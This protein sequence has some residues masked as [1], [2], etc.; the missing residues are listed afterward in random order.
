MTYRIIGADQKEYGPAEAELVNDWI[1]Q[2]RMDGATLAIAEGAPAWKPLSAYPEFAAALAQVAPAPS[3]LP[4]R[5]AGQ[6]P[7]DPL[8]VAGVCARDC[9]GA[10]L[11]LRRA[12]V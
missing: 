11:L 12:A 5:A 8:A 9:V 10:V 1:L 3:P 7:M 2:R 6:P 4:L